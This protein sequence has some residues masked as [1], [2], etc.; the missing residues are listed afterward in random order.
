[1]VA[2]GQ[3]KRGRKGKEERNYEGSATRSTDV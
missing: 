1:M 2:L 3:R